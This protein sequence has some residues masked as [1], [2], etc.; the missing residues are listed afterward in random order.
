MNNAESLEAF[1][2]LL[3]NAIFNPAAVTP[4]FP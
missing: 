2:R 4:S 3:D 1:I